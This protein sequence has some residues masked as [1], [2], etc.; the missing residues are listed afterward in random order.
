MIESSLQGT[1]ESHTND[2]LATTKELSHAGS[3]HFKSSNESHSLIAFHINRYCAFEFCQT[4]KESNQPRYGKDPPK[5]L[6]GNGWFIIVDIF[7]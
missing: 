1:K 2:D 4:D 6:Q 5:H 3:K 7:A